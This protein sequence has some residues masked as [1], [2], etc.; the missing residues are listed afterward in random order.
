MHIIYPS[1]INLTRKSASPLIFQITYTVG[2]VILNCWAMRAIG[3]P[4][5]W[6]VV[7]LIFKKYSKIFTNDSPYF[8]LIILL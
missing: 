5:L 2:R 1:A 7:N 6:S 4:C 8:K 3:I